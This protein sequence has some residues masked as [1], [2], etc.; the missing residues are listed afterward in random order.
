M[1][2]EKKLLKDMLKAIVTI[3]SYTTASHSIFVDDERTQAAILYNLF[4]LSET[5]KQVPDQFQSSNP[6]IPWSFFLG[7]R[8]GI[9]DADDQGKA[10]IIRDFLQKDL[11]GLKKQIVQSIL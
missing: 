7:L 8:N 4:I 9:L 6:E 2:D 1:K 10:Q 5:A 11:T 3:E